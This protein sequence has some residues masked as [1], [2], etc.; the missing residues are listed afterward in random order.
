MMPATADLLRRLDDWAAAGWLRRLD[1]ALATFVSQLDPHAPPALLAAVAVL[2]CMEGKGHTCLPLSGLVHAPTDLLGWP[3]A[4]RDEL[5]ALWR[6]LPGD[7][8]GWLDALRASPVVEATGAGSPGNSRSPD[9]CA[10]GEGVAPLVL[11]ETGEQPRLYLRRYWNHERAIAAA[12]RLRTAQPIVVDVPRARAWLDQLFDRAAPADAPPDRVDWQ[13]CACA[14]ALQGRFTIITG[15][16][17]TGKTYTAA[18]LLALLFALDPAP[19]RLRI[20]LAAPTGKAAARLKQSIDGSLTE[21]AGKLAGHLNLARLTERMGAARTLHALLGATP[22]SRNFRYTARHPLDLDVLIVDEASMVHM[23][24]MAALLLALPPN[25]RLV[26]LGD[27]DQLSSVEAG[28]V[29]GDLCRGAVYG[30][31]D[32]LTCDYLEQ[33]TGQRIPAGLRAQGSQVT[34]LAQHTVMLR[35]SQRF[36][37]SIG[38]LARAVNDGDAMLARKVLNLAKDLVVELREGQTP[39]AVIQLAAQGRA[40]ASDCYAGYLRL[41]KE[42]AASR[43]TGSDAHASWVASVLKAFDRFRILCAVHEGEWGT[44]ALNRTV[45]AA[46]ASAKLIPTSGE[47]YAGRPVMVLRNDRDLGVSNGDVGI[48]LP[49][50]TDASAL[51]AYFLDGDS[52]RSVAVSR[53][54]H[55]ETAYAMTVHKSQGSEFAHV[56]LVLPPG[57][58]EYLTREL[59]YTGITRARNNLTLFDAGQGVLDAAIGRRTQRASGLSDLA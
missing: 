22:D 45:R 51:R 20:A 15:G 37:G 11:D 54:A 40:R 41:I 27:K 18:R 13:K 48:V 44:K 31:Y 5:E 23:E 55:I 19:E 46:L 59:V 2:G 10:Q 36:G 52:Q 42:R 28:A 33:T 24:M 53:L 1:S 34:S 38:D 8:D 9:A 49:S 35:E 17:G 6:S 50:A 32:A 43:Q 3:Q 21:L 25:A 56:A 7:P 58:G 57:A 47:W 26:L 14:L 16:P 39:A 4:Q 29:L 12:V 30:G